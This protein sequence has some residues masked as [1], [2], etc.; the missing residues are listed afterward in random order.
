MY[1]RLK[2][3]STVHEIMLQAATTFAAGWNNLYFSSESVCRIKE[4]AMTLFNCYQ[5]AVRRKLLH[6]VLPAVSQQGWGERDA[7]YC[8]SGEVKHLQGI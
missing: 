4:I 5:S 3:A 8:V 6:T 1:G 2:L 7:S